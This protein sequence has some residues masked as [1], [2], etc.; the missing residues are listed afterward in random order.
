MLRKLFKNKTKII[1]ILLILIIFPLLF[2]N[3]IINVKGQGEGRGKTYT[4]KIN[5]EGE[6]YTN[7]EEG[8]ETF[9]KNEIVEVTITEEEYW[10]FD[11]W[12]GDIPEENKYKKKIYV[13]MDNDKKIT[14]NFKE[15]PQYYLII[16]SNGEGNTNPEKGKHTYYEN[17]EIKIIS[18][19]ENS[20]YFENWSGISGD[21]IDKEEIIMKIQDNE[22]IIAN[23]ERYSFEELFS[24]LVKS[25]EKLVKVMNSVEDT[26]F[27]TDN[28][29][30]NNSLLTESY[31]NCK[32][33]LG[34]YYDLKE[35]YYEDNT[36]YP[37][38]KVSNLKEEID[39]NIQI[40]E[41]KL[42]DTVSSIN[43]EK[44]I[45]LYLYTDIEKT[46]ENG[47]INN[48]NEK[49]NNFDNTNDVIND[50]LDNVEE[51]KIY[52]VDNNTIFN[53]ASALYLL[54][55]IDVEEGII[56]QPPQDERNLDQYK[57]YFNEKFLIPDNIVKKAE[58]N[59]NNLKNYLDKIPKR[60]KHI[61]NQLDYLIETFHNDNFEDF[62][63]LYENY[64]SE[65]TEYVSKIENPDNYSTFNNVKESFNL[66]FDVIQEN[67]MISSKNILETIPNFVVKT[68]EEK[69]EEEKTV[70][71]II[72]KA[73]EKYNDFY[74][75]IKKAGWDTE[76]PTIS[77]EIIESP[78]VEKG[79]DLPLGEKFEITSRGLLDLAYSYSYMSEDVNFMIMIL[80]EVIETRSEKVNNMF[81]LLKE[82][83][84]IDN[85]SE[86]IIENSVNNSEIN[87]EKAKEEYENI[88]GK[89]YSEDETLTL[90][91]DEGENILDYL[92]PS[93]KSINYSYNYVNDYMYSW[94]EELTNL[95]NDINDLITVAKGDLDKIE[96]D[97]ENI[98]EN[99][100][101]VENIME[102]VEKES[103][104]TIDKK[105][106]LVI[107]QKDLE[108]SHY[109]IQSIIT[110][111]KKLLD[112]NPYKKGLEK[113]YPLRSRLTVF[114]EDI[115]IKKGSVENPYEYFTVTDSVIDNIIAPDNSFFLIDGVPIEKNDD[116]ILEKEKKINDELY[117]YNIKGINLEPFEKKSIEIY[118]IGSI[119]NNTIDNWNQ[120]EEYIINNN[121]SLESNFKIFKKF[122]ELSELNNIDYLLSLKELDKFQDFDS[123]DLF[124]KDKKYGNPVQNDMI[125][126][127]INNNSEEFKL[128]INNYPLTFYQENFS[129]DK[130]DD[131][132]VLNN[133]YCIKN[134]S[135]YDY[136]NVII[137]N[138]LS[139]NNNSVKSGNTSIDIKNNL[140]NINIDKIE[141]G[142]VKRFN[143]KIEGGD[144]N[145]YIKSNKN[146]LKEYIERLE[147]DTVNNLNIGEDEVL[148]ELDKQYERLNLINSS[149]NYDI[150]FEILKKVYNNLNK[151]ER[152]IILLK[153]NNPVIL[154]TSPDFESGINIKKKND[155]MINDKIINPSE[156]VVNVEYNKNIPQEFDSTQVIIDNKVINNNF[157]KENINLNFVMDSKEIKE[158]ILYDNI[159]LKVN[160]SK[161]S[162]I[163]D[164]FMN[165]W[166]NHYYNVNFYNILYNDSII[167]FNKE[168]YSDYLYNPIIIEEKY[169]E[170]FD[171]SDFEIKSYNK[172]INHTINTLNINNDKIVQKGEIVNNSNNTEK[173]QELIPFGKFVEDHNS[174]NEKVGIVRKNEN[175]LLKNYEIEGNNTESYTIEYD[176]S[177]YNDSI[178]GYLL[179]LVFRKDDL[180]EMSEKID[181]DYHNDFKEI[182]LLPL[183]QKMP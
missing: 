166:K 9:S 120:K 69:Y 44:N 172:K 125:S 133:D 59:H 178:K 57:D 135:K 85:N 27:F 28:Y 8:V 67:Y 173:I 129:Y 79:G 34:E 10:N 54:G 70:T 152:N 47:W 146:L 11:N 89:E 110:Q 111:I 155:I 103:G 12:S 113:F 94:V 50:L 108:E 40:S 157:K 71:E 100:K 39:K 5:I 118:Y 91:E 3:S 14:A 61:N 136:N 107:I 35:Y 165:N 80:F 181:K 87:L 84:Y 74:E 86:E 141:K 2:T 168:D 134:N 142:E 145:S 18:E 179:F 150:N 22:N 78:E 124:K 16:N 97:T 13:K 65:I 37:K 122:G 123:I 183:I 62:D 154:E 138:I 75:K 112:E 82:G 144:I 102:N 63:K 31:E 15:Y 128:N 164:L 56:V 77:E 121:F 153:N 88:T 139:V 55:L 143:V 119:V 148:N 38:E 60:I 98:E 26:I 175:V 52:K 51:E 41:Q 137:E 72:E 104:D 130:N 58:Y 64:P 33:L 73:A 117:K 25:K 170:I 127:N 169:Q 158:V 83:N 149:E 140:L 81:N 42:Y 180:L 116:I 90:S 162:S 163:Q 176:I 115:I 171:D 20:W 99:I 105:D 132:F 49:Y 182:L 96:D 159:S 43:S 167:K 68:I 106:N 29:G 174:N 92:L 36:N 17:E 6:G 46:D 160:N 1:I 147:S 32:K 24:N 151:L 126:F 45:N 177:D 131:G 4:L 30:F 7:P 53:F 48:I 161:N 19:P 76:I 21:K 109:R 101:I 93:F 95:K 114:S 23:F 66:S 156:K